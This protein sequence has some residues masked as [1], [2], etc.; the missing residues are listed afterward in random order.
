MLAQVY[1]RP[2]YAYIR[3]RWSRPPEEAVDLTQDFFLWILEGHFTERLDPV[4]GR[5]RALVRACLDNFMKN[6][7]RRA[8]R[9]RRGGK[10]KILSLDFGEDPD[11][12]LSESLPG[13]RTEVSPEDLLDHQWRRAVLLRASELLRAEYEREGRAMVFRAFER[14]DLAPSDQD[15]PTYDDLA[16][17]FG[18]K[19][20]DVDNYLSQARKRLYEKIREVVAQSVDSPEALAAELKIIFPRGRGR[21]G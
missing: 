10:V 20:S 8:R 19:K 18:V 13:G 16:G 5:L 2:V 21:S 4:R 6:R 9:I 14:Y 15:R 11:M 1:W 7:L 17:E 12:F 3:L